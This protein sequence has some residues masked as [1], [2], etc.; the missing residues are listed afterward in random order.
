[1]S[2]A[3][4]HIIGDK[5]SRGVYRFY[6]LDRGVVLDEFRIE[7]RPTARHGW[8]TSKVWERLNERDRTISRPEVPLEAAAAAVEHFRSQIKFVLE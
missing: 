4:E 7:D 3:F 6:L 8:N 5:L 2:R 1:M